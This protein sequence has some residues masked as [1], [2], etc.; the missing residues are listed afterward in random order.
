[1]NG[2]FIDEKNFGYFR[3][4][5]LNIEIGCQYFMKPNWSILF[6]PSFGY[7]PFGNDSKTGIIE[8]R[9]G[10]VYHF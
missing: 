6:E 5:L 8:L 2:E 3:L 10:I 7:I 9:S 4:F 1:M